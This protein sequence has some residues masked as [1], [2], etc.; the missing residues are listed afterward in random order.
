MMLMLFPKETC[1][2]KIHYKESVHVVSFLFVD[3]VRIYIHITVHVC[4]IF[5]DELLLP[6]VR[7]RISV[8]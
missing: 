6:R 3:E 1:Q 5:F 4:T 8:S 7:V 2:T